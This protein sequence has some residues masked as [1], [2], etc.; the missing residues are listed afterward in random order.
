VARS[1][2]Q[3]KGQTGEGKYGVSKAVIGFVNQVSRMPFFRTIPSAFNSEWTTHQR[4][5]SI[6]VVNR[7]KAI[8]SGDM[9]NSSP[10]RAQRTQREKEIIQSRA[11]G[12][13]CEKRSDEAISFFF[14]SQPLGLLRFARN[15][16]DQGTRDSPGDGNDN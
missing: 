16:T 14:S 6:A 13:H 3:S 5:H 2:P 8:S 7:L 11:V 4:V 12:C 9:E 15:D 10:Q 1:Y